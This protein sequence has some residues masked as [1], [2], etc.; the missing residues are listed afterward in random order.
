[1]MLRILHWLVDALL[2]VDRAAVLN[3]ESDADAPQPDIATELRTIADRLKIEAFDT[4]KG[5]VDYR[6]LGNSSTY[7]QYKRVAAGL[8]RFDPALK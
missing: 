8:R 5:L 4:E 3:G 1:M 7:G 2:R 6:A